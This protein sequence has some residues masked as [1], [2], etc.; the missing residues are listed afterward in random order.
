MLPRLPVFVPLLAALVKHIRRPD[1]ALDLGLALQELHAEAL[2]RV[3]GDVA[4]HDLFCVSNFEE[5]AFD[6]DGFRGVA[7]PESRVVGREGEKEIA[8][9][10]ESRRVATCWVLEIEVVG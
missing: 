9:W 10:W 6:G 3:P 5:N 4:V 1:Q 8:V 2:G 7:Y